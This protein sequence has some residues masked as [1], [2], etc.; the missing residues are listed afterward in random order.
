MT[1]LVVGQRLGDRERSV[2]EA[3]ERAAVEV[4]FVPNPQVLR[5]SLESYPTRCVMADS[6]E[7]VREIARVLRSNAGCFGVP[8][9]A[10][11]EHIS[12]RIMLELHAIGA[13]DVVAIHDLG[14]LTRR[15][16]A[17]SSFDP[18]ARTSLF[19]GS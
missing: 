16:A 6:P 12:D 3:I 1:A 17:L 4:V 14:G 7:D 13:D 19:Q 2:R 9:I 11:A 15:L 18:Q 10:L 8:L 5:E